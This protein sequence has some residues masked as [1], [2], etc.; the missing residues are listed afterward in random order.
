[1]D[2]KR[3][4]LGFILLP[5]LGAAQIDLSGDWDFRI[6]SLDRGVKQGWYKGPLDEGVKLPGSLTTNNKGNDITV[7]TKWTSWVA[8]SAWYRK[9]MFEKWRKPGNV[10]VIFWLQPVKEYVGPAWYTREFNVPADMKGSRLFLE[11]ERVHWESQ[12]W[13]DGKPLGMRN[14]LSTP[15]YYDLGTLSPGKHRVSVR[16]DNSHK[17]NVGINAHSLADHTQTNWNGITGKMLITARPAVRVAG[18]AIYPDVDR[19]EVKARVRFENSGDASVTA[20]LTLSAE[21]KFAPWL[22]TVAPLSKSVTAKPGRDSIEIIY[23][24]GKEFFKWSEHEPYLYEVTAAL[25][26]AGAKDAFS[27]TFGMRK[28]STNSRQFAINGQTIFLRGTLDCA[29]FPRTGYPP[30]D[31]AEWRRVFNVIKSHGLNHVRYHSWCPPEAAFEA[32]DQLGVYLQVEGASW[33]DG[34]GHD[35]P[36][37][38]WIYAETQRIMDEYGN[39][40]SFLLYT[41]G[42]EPSGEG[43]KEFLNDFVV[44]WSKADPR[45]KYTSGAGWPTNPDNHYTNDG[46]PRIYRWMDGLESY[47][48]KNR[49]TTDFDWYDIISQYKI[50]Y[51]AHEIGNWCA[52]PNFKEIDKYDGCAVRARNFEVFREMLADNGMAHLGDKF[53]MASGKQQVMCWKAE[54]EAALR[55]PD[56]AGFQM[57]S[58][59][60]FP[61]QGTALVGVLDAFWEEKGYVSPSEFARFGG[62]VVPLARMKKLIYNNDENLEATVEIAN[63]SGAT[64]SGVVPTW[65]LTRKNGQIVTSGNLPQSN[66]AVGNGIRLGSINYSL[67]GIAEPSQ[68]KLTVDVAGYR[69]DW[70]IWVYPAKLP[71]APDWITVTDTLDAK[72]VKKLNEGGYVLFTPKMGSI[73]KSKGGEITLALSTIFW[74]TGWTVHVQPPYAFGVLVDPSHP[75]LAQF[76][77]DYHQNYNWWDAAMHGNA[78]KLD[79]LDKRLQPVVRIIDDWFQN[80]TLGLIA[81]ARVGKGKIIICGVDL[82]TDKE[83]RPEARQLLGSLTSYMAGPH[84]NPSVTLTAQKINSIVN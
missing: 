42:N 1:M 16:V 84:F 2:M 21:S 82:L 55:T 30:T 5:L 32:A 70:D 34:V 43:M 54:F 64:L 79:E 20:T 37:C 26:A 50:P 56:F 71:A 66:V 57:L 39:H 51:V 44:Y 78:I 18:V 47:I 40:P 6:D 73:K 13:I 4:L 25:D 31:V 59:S 83:N 33:S 77:T 63:F 58:L 8:D 65:M 36:F 49:P 76:P 24:M 22:H 29:T 10:K 74:N 45:H 52:Y 41:Y 28:I 11:L 61:G 80:Y 60:D 15:H 75:A 27:T 46:W 9:P 14:S 19:G 35:K 48:N 53:L 7:D 62:K 17:I 3:L 12:L 68:M 81:E 72:T 67:A 38:D 69:N 23:P